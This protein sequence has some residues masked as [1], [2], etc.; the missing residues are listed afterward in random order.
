IDELARRFSI[1]A[2]GHSAGVF[3][4]EKLAWVNRHYLK[5]ADPARIAELAIPFFAQHGVRLAPNGSGM[6][7]LASAM[8]MATASVDRVNQVPLR[9]GFLFEYDAAAALRS[10]AVADE[11]RQA[12]ARAVIGAP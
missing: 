4:E 1:D 8:A 5:A 10:P 11:M 9:L 7:F 12:D 2:V 3:D 6:A